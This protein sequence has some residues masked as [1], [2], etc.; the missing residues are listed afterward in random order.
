[1]HAEKTKAFLK[2]LFQRRLEE[3]LANIQSAKTYYWP[4]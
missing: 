2:N 4:C 1:M 3:K